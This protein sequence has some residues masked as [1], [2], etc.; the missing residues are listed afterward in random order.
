KAMPLWM[1]VV[2]GEKPHLRESRACCL[3]RSDRFALCVEFGI[4]GHYHL[5]R[6]DLAGHELTRCN[7]LRV[8]DMFAGINQ[9]GAD[10][11]R[12]SAI[13]GPARDDLTSRIAK[14]EFDSLFA[15][16]AQFRRAVTA[17]RQPDVNGQLADF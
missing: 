13:L 3:R 16:E 12:E 5:D 9:E 14:Q 6:K 8:F 10:L 17:I 4:G 15:R 1:E 2:I 7:R 11:F